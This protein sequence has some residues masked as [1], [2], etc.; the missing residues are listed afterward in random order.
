MQS[1][2]VVI[3]NRGTSEKDGHIY[4]MTAFIPEDFDQQYFVIVSEE[5]MVAL[6]QAATANPA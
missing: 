6:Y 3:G 5:G 1:P 4:T 2:T